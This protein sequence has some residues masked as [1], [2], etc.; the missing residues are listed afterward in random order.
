MDIAKIRKK[1]KEG[2]EEKEKAQVASTRN[3]DTRVATDRAESPEVTPSPE[4]TEELRGSEEKPVTKEASAA[5][6]QQDETEEAPSHETIT[7]PAESVIHK[8]VPAA[9]A[10]EPE[11][12]S[13]AIVELLTFHLSTE[14]FAFRVFDIEEILRFQRI[15][16]VPKV[17]DYILG[18][19]SLRG[20]IIPVIDLKKR[21]SIKGKGDTVLADLQADNSRKKILTLKGPKGPAGAV[22]D[23]VK[24]VI[25]ISPSEIVE[26]PAHLSEAELMFIEG[27]VLYNSRF[28]SVIRMEK[29][30]EIN[31]K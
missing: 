31:L 9:K 11:E 10:A 20:K 17:P 25:R 3:S 19:T 26:P 13:E 7:P 27:V 1:I 29:I 28:I 23:K 14:E 15:M 18:I 2:K 24:G 6:E 8:A 4:E 22:I 16:P 12:I 30:L 21:L 5:H